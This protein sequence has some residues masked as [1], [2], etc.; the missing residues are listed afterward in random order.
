MKMALSMNTR[1]FKASASA[2]RPAA[3]GRAAVSVK[4]AKQEQVSFTER[5]APSVLA[6][7]MAVSGATA[8]DAVYAPVARADDEET[9]SPYQKR[10]AELEKRRELLREAREK[11]AA[12]AS[13]ADE[14]EA[15]PAPA[16]AAA[17]RSSDFAAQ[18]KRLKSEGLKAYEDA[19][20]NRPAVPPSPEPE[21][22]SAPLFGGFSFSKPAETPAPAAPAPPAPAAPASTFSTPP[23]PWRST[24]APV[25]PK[26][27]PAPAPVAPAP[28][29]VRKY[30]A[31]APAPV[32][33]VEAPA[34]KKEEKKSDVETKKPPKRRRRG[35]MP[36]W[37]A[38]M[39]V[40]GSFV[41]VGLG[42]T[43]YSKESGEVLKVAGQKAVE[44]Y[45]AAEKLI[46]SKVKPSA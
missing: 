13:G 39:L 31:P 44:A 16:P 28:A 20:K 38:E 6:A 9:M 40:L 17:A 14:S 32:K 36:L 19:A 5:L 25:I 15:A 37:L 26:P 18:A 24:P 34:P 35:V 3:R 1:A 46:N 21:E 33:K 22:E 42:A 30:E 7:I 11:A 41:G 27:A 29:P 2:P 23:D 10:Q 4:A 12:R 8:I 43:K 45:N